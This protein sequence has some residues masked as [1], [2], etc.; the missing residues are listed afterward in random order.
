MKRVLLLLAICLILLIAFSFRLPRG[1]AEKV[2][3][4][5]LKW[6]YGGRYRSWCETGWYS[7]PAVADLDGDGKPEVIASSYTLFVLN[8]EDGTLQGDVDPS[9]GCTWP[10]VVTADLDADGDT[11]I[12]VAQGSGYITVYINRRSSLVPQ[13]I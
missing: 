3:A 8:S 1:A 4:P 11:E 6:Q 9:G 5:I 12:V 13:A 7:S 2:A 10:G